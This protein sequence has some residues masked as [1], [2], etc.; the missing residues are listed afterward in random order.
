MFI[1]YGSDWE[2]AWKEHM[3]Q[4]NKQF[5]KDKTWDMKASDMKL[6]YKDIPF[7]TDLKDGINPYPP[8]VATT[9]FLKTDELPDGTPRRNAEGLEVFNFAAELK[10]EN[11]TGSDMYVC[12]VLSRTGKLSDGNLYNYTVLAKISDDDIVQVEKVPHAAITF[13]DQPYQSD[14]HAAGAFR[15][16]ISIRDSDFPQ[17][18]RNL[19]P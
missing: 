9:C 1:D 11:F 13:V 6:Q 8:S 12:D 19:R 10:P 14:L 4:W 5:G 17:A 15:H 2:A 18:W 3:E 7:A 16:K